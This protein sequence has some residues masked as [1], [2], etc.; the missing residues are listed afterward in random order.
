MGDLANMHYGLLQMLCWCSL[1]L[2]PPIAK[3]RCHYAIAISQMHDGFSTPA[4]T[5]ALGGGPNSPWGIEGLMV[6]CEPFAPLGPLGC[7]GAL[8]TLI[9]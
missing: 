4:L 2:A 3:R 5:H 1:A 8:C 6:G 7:K 9:I